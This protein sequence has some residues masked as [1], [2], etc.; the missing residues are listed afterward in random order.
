M[1]EKDYLSS[2]ITFE[3]TLD[4]GENFNSYVV[5]YLSEDIKIYALMTVPFGT[6][7]DP[8]WPVIIFNHGYIKPTEYRTT[9]NYVSY[10]D[11]LASNGYI[12][13]KSDFRG[14]GDSGGELVAGGGY[15]SSAYTTDVLN[16]IEALKYYED[17]DTN[18]IGMWGHSMGGQVTLR[19]MIVSDDIKAGVIWSGAVAPYPEIISRWN[20]MGKDR[21]NPDSGSDREL[22]S[23]ARY[24]GQSFSSWVEE[25]FNK[26]GTPD[27]NPEF[28]KTISPNYYLDDLS[29]PIS[30]HHSILDH[31]VPIAWSGDLAN[32]LNAL[33]IPFEFQK[34]N[35]DDHNISKNY[36]V[37][38]QRTVA[39]FDQ[40]LKK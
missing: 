28:W 32:E 11:M 19:A 31:I 36:R 8:G 35:D 29:G 4:P 16:A 1:R 37:A 38:M 24:W 25:F 21:R 33:S 40:Y 7:P 34:Y 5:S 3:R 9:D 20:F 26:Y 6:K 18:N 22:D 23:N 10:M 14:H 27:Q 39:F 30:L 13:F 12:V 2:P 15:G 17:A